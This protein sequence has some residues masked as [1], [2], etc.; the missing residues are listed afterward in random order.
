MRKIT[1]TALTATAVAAT[2]TALT[3]TPAW[4]STIVVT[5]PG[6][7]SPSTQPITGENSGT[8]AAITSSSGVLTCVDVGSI[9]A[10][11]ATG[12]VKVGNPVAAPADPIGSVTGLTFSNCTVLGQ[13]AAVTPQNLPWTLSTT[14]DTTSGVTPGQL[15]GVRVVVNIPSIPCSATFQGSTA[16]NG[17][18]N[19][20]HTNPTG[21]AGTLSLPI[22]ATNNLI[23]ASVSATCPTNIV[24]NGDTATLAGTIKLRGVNSTA[25]EGPTV[26]RTP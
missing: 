20:T 23:A 1:R 12:T 6:V 19:G 22:T 4:A 16:T 17:F 24:K 7:P 21:G 5:M 11:K 15:S 2:A 8:V 25:N 14:G 9:K 18:I 10:L 3:V 26:T 13:V